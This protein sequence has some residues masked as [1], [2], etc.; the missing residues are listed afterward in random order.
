[1]KPARVVIDVE[2]VISEIDPRLYGSFL[3]HLGRAIYGGIYEPEHPTA[4][5]HGFR[6]DV[7][8]LV[9]E[10]DMPII[11]YPGGNFVASYNWEDGIG[12][13]RGTAGPPRSRLALDRTQHIRD[14]RVRRLESV[15][16]GTAMMLAVNLGTRGVTEAMAM[17]EYCNHPSGTYWSDLRIEHG[18]PQPHDVRVWCLGNEVDGP[19]QIAQK[20]AIEYGRVAAETG[21]AMKRFDPSLELVACGSSNHL[22]PT[23]PEWETTVLDLSYDFVDHL[24]LH[25]YF[26]L[27]GDDYGSFL[28]Q[29]QIMD[30]QIETVVAAC[31]LAKA[32]KRS[33]RDIQLCF[34]EWNVWYHARA[35]DKI[36]ISEQD[37]PI[38]P[39]ITEDI[40]TLADALVVG[41]LLNSLIRR[42]DRVKIACL[43]Q[44]VN[45]IAPIMTETGGRA[46]KQTIYF[47]FLQASRWGR[48][49]AL[50][51]RVSSPRYSCRQFGDVPMLDVSATHDP[52][53]GSVTIFAVNRSGSEALLVEIDLRGIE[54]AT[55]I[56]HHVLTGDDLEAVNTADDPDRVLT[57]A[58]QPR[59]IAAD[60]MLSV[61][62]PTAFWTRDPESDSFR[63]RLASPE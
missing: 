9:R 45:V 62:M 27:E 48:G 58:A 22:L 42:A 12:P 55:S 63:H 20:T 5:A 40:Y 39:P 61:V 44:L 28:A 37:W 19:W 23:Y 14:Q 24:S 50:D 8:E 46:W 35:K 3:E 54:G 34:D 11:R 18:Y 29:S 31:N 47:P 56:E 1:M 17:L 13:R 41:T 30:E 38:A 16:A 2:D 15:T 6:Q 4:D 59:R 7:L 26:V 36:T 43:A 10:L 32:K 60:D 51:T 53:S 21:K 57:R 49:V 25:N 52:E 33:S